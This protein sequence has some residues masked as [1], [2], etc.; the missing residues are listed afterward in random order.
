MIRKIINTELVILV[1]VPTLGFTYSCCRGGCRA[2]AS[3]KTACIS[4]I[5]WQSWRQKV[6]IFSSLSQKSEEDGLKPAFT[7]RC[8]H[9]I[10]TKFKGIRVKC[11]LS[12][13]YFSFPTYTIPFLKAPFQE[14]FLRCQNFPLPHSRYS[15][16][17]RKGRRVRRWASLCLI[18]GS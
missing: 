5:A 2:L 11:C 4:V 12:S 18:S 10:L 14:V 17:N 16:H 13:F 1:R 3:E 8:Q 9:Q 7:L 6:L 15:S